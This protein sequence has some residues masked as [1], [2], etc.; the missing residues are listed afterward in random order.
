MSAHRTVWN[1]NRIIAPIF[2]LVSL[3]SFLT[4][5]ANSSKIMSTGLK[6]ELTEIR[7]TTDGGIS[8]A[9]HV[10][11]ENIV[12]YLLSRIVHKI[13]LNGAYLGQLET[14]SALAIPANTNT[15][16]TTVLSGAGAEASRAVTAAASSGTASYKVDTK[17]TILIY[18]DTTEKADL[19]N[20][21]QVAVKTN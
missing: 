14:N 8:V 17:I 7:Q 1:M 13:H 18:G 20:S 16:T 2:L 11:N 5:C 21:G 9:W 15:G 10:K 19:S 4:G 6:I 12:P 3:V